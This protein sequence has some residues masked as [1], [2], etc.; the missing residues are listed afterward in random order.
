MSTL[1]FNSENEPS[2]PILPPEL[3]RAIFEIAAHLRPLWIP[4]FMLVAQ[5]VKTWVE[6]LLYRTIALSGTWPEMAADLKEQP[7]FQCDTLLPIIQSNSFSFPGD[8]VR[9]LLLGFISSTDAEVVLS[10]CR[11]VEN[12]WIVMKRPG[13]LFPL[14]GDLPLKHLYC[15]VEDLFGPERPI[16]FTHR[17]FTNITHL[18]IFDSLRTKG[19]ADQKERWKKLCLIPHLTHL[20]FNRTGL[21][22]MDVWL[23]LLRTC[24]S[25]RVLVVR[26]AKSHSILHTLIATYAEG[27]DLINDPRFMTMSCKFDVYDW[28]M[29]TLTGMDY[30]S[31]AEAGIVANYF[32]FRSP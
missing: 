17:V 7:R 14:I 32:S 21:V 18:H 12:L 9:N 3:E 5:R 29:G 15:H 11:S 6:P 19:G 30:W 23:T 25:L 4:Q 1:P 24:K 31:Q 2:L 13:D 16:D 27:P 26:D 10:A 20:C 28:R 22:I 8:S